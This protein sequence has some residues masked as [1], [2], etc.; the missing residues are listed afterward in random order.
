MIVFLLFQMQ[1]LYTGADENIRGCVLISNTEIIG[2]VTSVCDILI[3]I[4]EQ[5][6]VNIAG[7]SLL[8]VG[9][10]RMAFSY[11]FND[12][13]KPTGLC[14]VRVY[15]LIPIPGYYYFHRYCYNSYHFNF[16]IYDL[17]FQMV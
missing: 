2:W 3:L 8:E 7:Y 9:D 17:L 13:M 4:D 15:A 12:V 6:K 10:G 14:M 16:T 5:T 1:C 11:Q